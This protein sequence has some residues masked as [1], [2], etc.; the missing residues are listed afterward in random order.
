LKYFLVSNSPPPNDTVFTDQKIFQNP[1]LFAKTIESQKVDPDVFLSEPKYN[2]NL[3]TLVGAI[4]AKLK[5][6][7]PSKTPIDL[8]KPQGQELFRTAVAPALFGGRS[9]KYPAPSF[10]SGDIGRSLAYNAAKASLNDPAGDA[11]NIK[12][13]FDQLS[14]ENKEKFVDM[15]LRTKS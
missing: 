1:E 15:L 4:R 3:G 7:G 14:D 8:D 13:I 11:S 12:T 9:H 10:W 5:N 6:P 2:A